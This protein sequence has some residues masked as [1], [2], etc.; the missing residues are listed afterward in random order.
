M[1]CDYHKVNKNKGFKLIIM[2]DVIR[3]QVNIP[4][5]IVSA[6]ELVNFMLEKLDEMDYDAIVKSYK[7]QKG[8]Q[9]GEIFQVQFKLSAEKLIDDYTKFVVEIEF[10][11]NNANLSNVNGKKII[12]GDSK[13]VFTSKAETDYDKRWKSNP[14]LFFLKKIYEKYIYNMKIIQ[15]EDKA[16]E[17]IFDLIESV[18]SKLKVK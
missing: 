13:L 3:V 5:L 2:G 12:S 9:P 10:T 17:E 8:K 4:K 11:A 1:L 15:L 18:K 6:K 14:L 7:Y 16:E